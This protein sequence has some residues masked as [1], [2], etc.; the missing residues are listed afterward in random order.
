MIELN[1]IRKNSKVLLDSSPYAIIDFE[2]V[3][4]GKG[5]SFTRVKMRNL[6]TGQ[7]LERTFKSGEKFGQPDLDHRDMQYLYPEGDMYHFMDTGNYEQLAL[8]KSLLGDQ[9]VF[10][11]E[12]L[13]VTVLFFNGK[14][15][16]IEIPNFVELAIEYC[17]PGFKG[18]TAQ[19]ATKPAR[20]V[21]GHTVTV[22]LHLKEGDV[23]K[24]DTRT[25]DY[26]AK[27]SE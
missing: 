20:L 15:I 27:V 14:P 3:K 12:G 1:D 11:K 22:P 23:L 6:I 9:I 5:G 19:G 7:L 25:G 13:Q 2:H 4:P 8:E 18:D 16:N 21:G 17:E 24:I 26:V 10:L